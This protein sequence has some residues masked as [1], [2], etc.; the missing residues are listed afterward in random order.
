MSSKK[1]PALVADKAPA[2]WPCHCCTCQSV[3]SDDHDPKCHIHGEGHG[4]RGCVRHTVT[5]QRCPQ[6]NCGCVPDQDLEAAR[7]AEMLA[8]G[9]RYRI[10]LRL[11]SIEVITEDTPEELE[12]LQ[13]ARREAAIVQHEAQS[14]Q[15]QD[16]VDAAVQRALDSRGISD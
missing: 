12:A 14:K 13:E 15:F 11:A 3:P 9:E 6:A 8:R 1:L 7:H 5:P 10:Q 4:G 2:D 16:A